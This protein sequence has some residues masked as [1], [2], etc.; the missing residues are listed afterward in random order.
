MLVE[1]AFS[2]NANTRN[3]LMK[4]ILLSSAAVFAFAG[5]AA[6]DGHLGVTFSGDAN[7]GYNTSDNFGIVAVDDEEG[8]YSELDVTIG[9]AA[10]LDNGLVAAASIDLEDL[11]G[12][13]G[14]NDGA[15]YELSLSSDT[16]GLYY[17]DTNFAAQN[18]WVSAGDMESDGFSEADGEEALRGEVTYGNVTAQLSYVLADNGG[19]RNA[20][21]ELNQLSLGV[22]ADFGNFNVVAAYQ[23]ESDE[24]ANYYNDPG[25]SDNGDFNDAE[26]FGLS[27]GTSFSGADVRLAYADNGTT[28][29]LG[30]KV[31]YP[32]GPVTATAYFVSESA[33]GDNYGV[34]MAY[35]NGPIGVAL[36]YQDDQGTAKVGLE[37]SYDVGNGIMAY[38]GYLTQ[39][40]TD[41]RFYVAGTYD[42]GSGASVLVSYASDDSNVDEDEIGAGE[43]QD[44]T[45]VELS[46]AF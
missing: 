30:V 16:A 46:F 32:F 20:N 27:V 40:G 28:D 9:F 10:E 3:Y 42:L 25:F 19:N 18:V 34:N 6:A 2:Q 36:D 45:T 31:A 44:G 11:A 15:E 35:E 8:F 5:A 22:S 12:G 14:G 4:N 1:L 37:G 43:Y 21:E 24:A 26:V 17:G 7:L 41:D 39:D 23:A 38:A 29:S 13:V 33:G